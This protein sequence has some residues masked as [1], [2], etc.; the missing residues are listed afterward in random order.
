MRGLK[1]LRSARVISAGHAFIQNLYRGHYELGLDVDPGAE[2]RT[3][4]PNSPSPSELRTATS[5]LPITQQRNSA[6]RTAGPDINHQSPSSHGNADRVRGALQPPSPTPRPEPSS[7][8]EVTTTTRGTIPALS[9]T[10]RPTRRVDTRIHPG[11]MT[12]MTSSAPTSLPRVMLY[13]EVRMDIFDVTC[14]H[15]GRPAAF[16]IG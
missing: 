8:T 1:Q 2:S 3:H 9:A 12:W 10:S 7:T 6:P 4:S 13:V 11:R 15:G 14:C 5:S 16:K